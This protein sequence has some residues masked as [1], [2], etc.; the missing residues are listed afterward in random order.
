[1]RCVRICCCLSEGGFC[2]DL[3]DFGG[4]F[5]LGSYLLLS[6][7]SHMVG[8]ILEDCG[9]MYSPPASQQAQI[10]NGSGLPLGLGGMHSFRM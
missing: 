9:P 1:M 4:C 8:Y 10:P 7:S 5:L 2:F 6:V 3:Y